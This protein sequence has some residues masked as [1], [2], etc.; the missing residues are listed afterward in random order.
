[1]AADII[2]LPT[3]A[4]R[5]QRVRSAGPLGGEVRQFKRR[6]AAAP[7]T[8]RKQ[9][10]SPLEGLLACAL[11]GEVRGLVLFA[12]LADGDV[13]YVDVGSFPDPKA[14]TQSLLRVTNRAFALDGD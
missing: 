2:P 13:R 8:H 9:L 7:I 5:A 6:T 14:L 3:A 1:M 4:P 11:A 12:A 10:V